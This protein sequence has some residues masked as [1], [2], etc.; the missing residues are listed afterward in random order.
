[1]VSSF[2]NED[3]FDEIFNRASSKRILKSVS[4]SMEHNQET[5]STR[6]A[7]DGLPAVGPQQEYVIQKYLRTLF[8]KQGINSGGIAQHPDFLYL[9]LDNSTKNQYVSTLFIDIKGSTRLSLIY[10]LEFI[11][12]FKNA[13]LQTCIEIVRSFD[14]Y[15]HRL[16]G[17]ALMAFFGSSTMDKEQ[18]AIDSINCSLMCKLTLESAIKPWLERHK[19]F[20]ASTFGFRIGC[21]FGDD[22]EVLWGNYGFGYLGEISPTGLPVDLAAKLQ[23]L[24]SKN[25]IMIGQGII[26]FI[27]WPEDYS[28]IKTKRQSGIDV[29][30][31]FVTPNYVKKDGTNLN[32]SMRLL[33]YERCLEYLPIDSEVKSRLAGSKYIENPSIKFTCQVKDAGGTL[34]NYVSGTRFLEKNLGLIF[35]VSAVTASRL[36]FPLSVK[37]RKKNHGPDVPIDDLNEEVSV[38]SI[39]KSK[40]NPYS[41]CTII[42][43][44]SYRGL[45][46][47][48]C[49]IRDSDG[50][51]VYR[52]KI[53]V[54]IK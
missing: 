35:T 1:M 22:H 3:G 5:G 9:A 14:G 40:D 43:G 10:D 23:G 53:A 47:M 34:S 33:G 45:H 15:V 13:V 16:M 51:L 4:E 52:N 42:E 46:A 12:K 2:L 7:N 11:Y 28:S 36:K 25:E 27:K 20:D 29:P 54:L 31:E 37:F 17:D 48:G 32:Y 19:G 6:T 8:D 44:T 39:A 30:V 49:E 26:D 41:T 38:D 50:A 24:A 21:N 18:A